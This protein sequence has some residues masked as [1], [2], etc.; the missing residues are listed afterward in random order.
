[1]QK[2]GTEDILKSTVAKECVHETNNDNGAK[3]ITCA[4]SKI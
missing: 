3:I 1:M 4:T 2:L